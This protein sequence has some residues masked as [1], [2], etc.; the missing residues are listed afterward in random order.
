MRWWL[1]CKENTFSGFSPEKAKLMRWR[2]PPNIEYLLWRCWT[3]RKMASAHYIPDKWRFTLITENNSHWVLDILHDYK[4]GGMEE[5]KYRAPE[6]KSWGEPQ[7]KATVSCRLWAIPSSC[8]CWFWTERIFS[9]KQYQ[10]HLLGL[11]REYFTLQTKLMY[12]NHTIFSYRGVSD[13]QID[14]ILDY[15]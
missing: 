15:L 8:S 4:I 11:D 10:S 9:Q 12:G 7:L 5:H 14:K 2:H 13:F 1:S 3:G 6:T